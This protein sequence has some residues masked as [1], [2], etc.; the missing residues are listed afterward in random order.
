MQHA[1]PITLHEALY[2]VALMWDYSL[3]YDWPWKHQYRRTGDLVK[4]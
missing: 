1:R 2:V 4:D 3:M